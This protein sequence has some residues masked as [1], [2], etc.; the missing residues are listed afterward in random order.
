MS[1][2][3]TLS[4]FLLQQPGDEVST[5]FDM[6]EKVIGPLPASARTYRE[7]W[8]NDLSSKSRQSRAW[9]NVGWIVA[10]VALKNGN[11]VFRREGSST[12]SGCSGTSRVLGCVSS[13]P[14]IGCYGQLSIRR[15]K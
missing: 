7:W 10:Q 8:A 4:E 6:L 1:K 3:D 13:L 9:L 11:V 2:Y 12:P 5:T 15:G 14:L